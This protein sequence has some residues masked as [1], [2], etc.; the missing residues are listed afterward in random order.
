MASSAPQQFER[1]SAQGLP[2]AMVAYGHMC[3]TG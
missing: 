2:E 1:A 3:E